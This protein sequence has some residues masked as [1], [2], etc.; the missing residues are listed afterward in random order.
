MNAL[1]R[2]EVEA[3]AEVAPVRTE[4]VWL[5]SQL[6]FLPVWATVHAGQQ[7]WNSVPSTYGRNCSGTWR[8]SSWK[9]RTRLL[10]VAR[11]ASE[12]S[13]CHQ[14]SRG[15]RCFRDTGW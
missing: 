8:P 9:W 15:S 2:A 3:S 10:I 13:W 7:R 5:R 6:G 4:A 14:S 12:F 11:P 1:V